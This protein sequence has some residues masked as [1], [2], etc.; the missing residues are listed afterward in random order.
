MGPRFHQGE[1]IMHD[2][3]TK[4]ANLTRKLSIELDNLA[5]AIEDYR[6]LI[7]SEDVVESEEIAQA[8]IAK[9]MNQRLGGNKSA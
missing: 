4:L 5:V 7:R 6:I 1:V 3:P 8:A 9:A 2:S